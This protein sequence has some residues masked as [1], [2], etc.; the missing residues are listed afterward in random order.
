MFQFKGISSQDM[1]VIVAEEEH[2]IA[3]AAQR[4]EI[5]EIE[6]RDGA[7]FEPQGYSYIERPILVQC[8]NINKIDMILQWLNGEGEFVY[9]GRKTIAR[10]Y[11]EIEP[12]R[13]AS[14]RIID[15][16]FIRDPFWIKADDDFIEIDNIAYNGGNIE[17]RPI[18]RLEKSS[19]NTVDITINKIRL[20]YNFNNEEYVEINCE[21]KTVLYDNLIRNRQIEMGYEYP[22]LNVGENKIIINGGN[23]KIKIKNKDRWL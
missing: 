14:I 3:R 9:K 4:Y 2:F 15:T 11:T 19:S 21:E 13:S 5:T 17:S 8:L 7:I 22:F 6:G 16:T 23:A 1:Q 10:F 20:K 18:I 12:Q